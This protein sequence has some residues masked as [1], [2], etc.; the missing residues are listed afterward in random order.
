KG[1]GQQQSGTVPLG[2]LVA[3]DRLPTVVQLGESIVRGA[4]LGE[5]PRLAEGECGGVGKMCRAPRPVAGRPG[6]AGHH[7]R[8]RLDHGAA[9]V[10]LLST[11]NEVTVNRRSGAPR[12]PGPSA[13]GTPVAPPLPRCPESGSRPCRGKRPR[14]RHPQPSIARPTP[15]ATPCRSPGSQ[16]RRDTQ[17]TRPPAR[18]WRSLLV[19]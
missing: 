11:A 15:P 7:A 2:E 17:P 12:R 18:T 19:P 6:R 14:H 8:R 1:L 13:S 3:V 10:G 5:T 16:R 9:R 4:T